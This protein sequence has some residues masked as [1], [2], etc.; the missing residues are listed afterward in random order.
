MNAMGNHC[1]R[2]NKEI[3]NEMNHMRYVYEEL[4]FIIVYFILTFAQIEGEETEAFC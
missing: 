3:C 4:L 1:M 2:N